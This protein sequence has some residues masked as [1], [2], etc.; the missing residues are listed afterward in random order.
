MSMLKKIGD[1][2]YDESATLGKGTFGSVY[3]GFHNKTR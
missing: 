2:S 1:Y 3:R